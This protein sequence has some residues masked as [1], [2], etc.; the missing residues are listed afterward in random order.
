M[1]S[2]EFLNGLP[3]Y[4]NDFLGWEYERKQVRFPRSKKK[5]IRKKFTKNQRNYKTRKWQE[6]VAYQMGGTMIVNTTMVA[7]LKSKLPTTGTST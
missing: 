1:I 6:P 3:I 2:A 5:R 4:I 7:I